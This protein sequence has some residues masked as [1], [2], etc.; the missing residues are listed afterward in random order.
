MLCAKRSSTSANQ[1]N[2]NKQ[3]QP[4]NFV[5]AR[6]MFYPWNMSH[7]LNGGG[8]GAGKLPTK[9]QRANATPPPAAPTAVKDTHVTF[10]AGEEQVSL[11]GVPVRMTRHAMVFELFNPLA[12]PRLSEALTDF[13]AGLHDRSIYKGRAVVQ[14]VMNAGAKVVCE[15]ALDEGGWQATEGGRPS[16][17]IAGEFAQLLKDWQ[18][19]YKVSPEFK[20]VAADMQ[21]FLGDLQLWLDKV[22]LGLQL[23][24]EIERRQA[25][26]DV[27]QSLATPAIGAFA[28]LFEK[29]EKLALASPPDMRVAYSLYAKRLLHPLVLC[30]PF[31]HR[32]YEKPLGY[33]G[34]YEMV[35]MM[36]MEPFRGDSMY[37]KLLNAF[38]LNTPPVVAHRNRIDTLVKLLQAETLRVSRQKKRMSIFNLGCGPAAEIQRFMGDSILSTIADFTLLDFNDETVAFAQRTLTQIK[39]QNQR[40]T[41]L[42]VTKKSVA[43]LIK[44][45]AKFGYNR[46]DLVYCTGLFDYLPDHVCTALLEI[47]Y[48]LAAPGG[49]VLVSNVDACNPSRGWMECM[50][51]WYLVYR[52]ARQM[53]D[54]IPSTIASESVRV[55]SEASS[56][57]I[58]AEIRKPLNV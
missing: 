38:F 57:N 48:D 34:D 24:P 6:K 41:G 44:D 8:N 53:H 27:L 56:V 16:V 40:Q 29:F 14:N 47:F 13:K 35:R 36:T 52:D 28:S 49:L 5:L 17:Q 32:T 58:F 7:T 15:V 51:D 39:R 18:K 3:V 30:A 9:P 33:A 25:E 2:T 43:Q 42:Q 26:R 37:A 45:S 20:V 11:H 21:T 22:E 46:F 50:V 1:I 4:K 54:F 31:M 10:R 12:T 19:F 55:F 23:L